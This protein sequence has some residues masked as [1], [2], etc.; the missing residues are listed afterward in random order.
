M[1][2]NCQVTRYAQLVRLEIGRRVD[3]QDSDFRPVA[4]VRG[5]EEGLCLMCPESRYFQG[6]RYRVIGY[7]QGARVVESLDSGGA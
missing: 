2:Q 7:I 6:V 5:H 3:S 1:T 4:F